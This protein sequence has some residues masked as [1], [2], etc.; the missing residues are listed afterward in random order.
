MIDIMTDLTKIGRPRKQIE[1]VEIQRPRGKADRRGQNGEAK[2]KGR[3]EEAEIWRLQEKNC[4]NTEATPKRSKHKK[5]QEAE[6]VLLARDRNT[7]ATP[8]RSRHK[9]TQEAEIV[10]LARDRNTEATPKRSKHKKTPEAEI[11]LLAREKLGTSFHLEIDGRPKYGGCEK[12]P[13]RPKRGAHKRRPERP[14]KG[15]N[16]KRPK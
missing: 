8:K 2:R 14:K 13:E 3:A 4:R 6:I 11:V 15:R 7:E 10:L 12:R 1:E 16:T 9:K 5:T